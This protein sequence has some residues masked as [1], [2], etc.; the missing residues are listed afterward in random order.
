VGK[1]DNSEL[2]QLEDL[3][4]ETRGRLSDVRVSAHRRSEAES[5]SSSPGHVAMHKPRRSG[6]SFFPSMRD[7]AS[8]R[9]WTMAHTICFGAI[10]I[11]LSV[12][13]V[14]IW[15]EITTPERQSHDIAG[16]MFDVG[17]EFQRFLL[18]AERNQNPDSIKLRGE[19]YLSRVFLVRDASAYE[20]VREV[21]PVETLAALFE[22]AEVIAHLLEGIDLPEGRDALLRHLRSD[23]KMIRAMMMEV[24]T[25]DRDLWFES[26]AKRLWLL[27]K[28]MAMVLVFLVALLV[29]RFIINLKLREADEALTTQLA[30]REGILASV[31]AA[32]LGLGVR[33]EV[34]YSNRNARELLGPAARNGSRP[35]EASVGKG[36]LLFELASM[37]RRG[38]E[39]EAGDVHD[40][41]KVR[42]GNGPTT[43]HYMIRISSAVPS[44]GVRNSHT[45]AALIVVVN[46]V[47]TEEEAAI[48]R[49]EYDA[50]L[51]EASRVLAYAAMSGG[52]VHEISQPLAAM[53]NN[54]FAL[55]ATM[56][57][58]K[59]GDELHALADQL[60]MEVDRGIEVVR[61]IRQMGPQGLQDIGECDAHEA[62][63]QS[64]RLVSLGHHPPPPITVT[65]AKMP[66]VIAGSLPLIGQVVVNLLKNAVSASSA[67]GRA[68]AKVDIT[69]LGDS[70]EISVAD[71]GSG[72]SGDAA[73]T[74]FAPF[75]RSAQGGMGLGLAICQRIAADLGGSLSWENGQ[76][77]GA[78]FRFRVP[79]ARQEA[80]QR[81]ASNHE[82]R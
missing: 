71:F 44:D 51:G 76:Y 59:S 22:S 24:L 35:A 62:I 48:R 23:E 36:S 81:W 3:L 12:L 20:D 43:R 67:A 30:T 61:N 58:C 55:K 6:L 42:V 39:R 25:V 69:L 53:S 82:L 34:L 66:V 27:R 50:R 70:A 33:G 38:H 28:Y 7:F 54:V 74:M 40:M 46:D 45:G 2:T 31:D 14:F 29:A 52:I 75:S 57:L 1:S 10:A 21:L 56:T 64:I 13:C 26:R 80:I 37:L 49:E 5:P 72:V 9:Y 41:Q 17:Y 63:T 68:G 47:T 18:S 60:R 15:V 19:I 11:A 4:H 65:P 32:I 16:G 8:H 77:A 79:L 73:R 78:V